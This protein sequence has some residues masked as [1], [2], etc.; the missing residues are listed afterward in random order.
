MFTRPAPADSTVGGVRSAAGRCGTIRGGTSRCAR[1]PAS[2]RRVPV[3]RRPHRVAPLNGPVQQAD[4]L[5]ARRIRWRLAGGERLRPRVANHHRHADRHAPEP[6]TVAL[7]ERLGFLEELLCA[8]LIDL[9]DR[10]RRLADHH[11]RQDCRAARWYPHRLLLTV[12]TLAQPT[13]RRCGRAV[14]GQ[15]TAMVHAAP[16]AINRN[17]RLPTMNATSGDTR[18]IATHRDADIGDRRERPA[19]RRSGAEPP[20]GPAQSRGHRDAPPHVG[21]PV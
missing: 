3:E 15:G 9:R 4:E 20:N 21:V 2:W 7:A 1:E 18:G 11:V 16:A 10:R 13:C 8:L 5:W 19:T 12:S 14:P 6:P 17:A